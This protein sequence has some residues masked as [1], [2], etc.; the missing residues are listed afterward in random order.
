MSAK[1]IS[2]VRD[3]G[4]VVFA[5]LVA[6]FVILVVGIAWQLFRGWVF[7]ALTGLFLVLGLALLLMARKQ[8]GKRGKFLRLCAAGAVGFVAFTLLHNLFYALAQLSSELPV[9]PGVLE[10]LHAAFFV[11]GI[12]VC[13]LAFLIGSIGAVVVKG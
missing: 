1:K 13:P 3:K 10:F 2:A 7:L 9:L 11:V 5:A 8:R 6:V 4:T 12:I